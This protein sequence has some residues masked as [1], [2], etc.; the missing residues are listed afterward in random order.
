M[1]KTF[2]DLLVWQKAMELTTEIYRLTE[3]F[4][5]SETYGLTSQIRR[6]TI[7]IA[8]NIAEGCGRSTKRDFRSFV[9]IARGSSYEVHTQLLIAARLNYITADTLKQ[10]EPMVVEIAKML[11]GL[12]NYLIQ[13][14]STPPKKPN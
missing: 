4:P 2:R 13:A 5:K 9:D 7:S 1:A 10:A 3:K 14:P 6:A 12:S 11:T 8:S